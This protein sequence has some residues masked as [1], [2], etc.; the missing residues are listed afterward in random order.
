M[1][2]G[3]LITNIDD[4]SV[5]VLIDYIEPLGVFEETGELGPG[6]KVLNSRG[7]IDFIHEHYIQH[8]WK[9]E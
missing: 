3:G 6:W 2:R 4:G 1:K 9:E 5:V 7:E 8:E